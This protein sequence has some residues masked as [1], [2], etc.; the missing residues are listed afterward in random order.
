MGSVP[1]LGVQWNA[2]LAGI[3]GAR[4]TAVDAQTDVTA[5]HDAV[6]AALTAT[7]PATV[8]TLAGGLANLA[9]LPGVATSLSAS[10][11]TVSAE[12]AALTALAPTIQGYAT[13]ASTSAGAAATSAGQALA[14]RDTALAYRDAALAAR[15]LSFAA[16]GSTTSKGAGETLPASTPFTTLAGTPVNAV[17][18]GDS[19]FVAG[20]RQFYKVT[21]Y[22]AGT[23][24]ITW[25]LIGVALL[26][27]A[28]LTA[29]SGALTLTPGAAEH[30]VSNGPML[31]KG[32]AT[33]GRIYAFDTTALDAA[34]PFFNFGVV[35]H[36][37][38]AYPPQ[39]AAQTG[40]SRP[41]L[42]TYWGWNFNANGTRADTTESALGWALESHWMAPHGRLVVEPHLVFIDRLGATHRLV[43]FMCDKDGTRDRGSIRAGLF[44]LYTTSG[45]QAIQIETDSTS[46]YMDFVRQVTLRQATNN[47]A[48]LQQRNAAGN[49]YIT[50]AYLDASDR[51]VLGNSTGGILLAG[52]V[53]LN[54]KAFLGDTVA[55]YDF[56]IGN[57]STGAANLVV[58]GRTEE[59]IRM[60]RNGHDTWSMRMGGSGAS[61]LWWV[62]NNVSG[63]KPMRVYD[64]AD[65][66]F[67]VRNDSVSLGVLAGE[68]PASRLHVNGAITQHQLAAPTAPASGRCI[69]YMDAATGNIVAQVNFGGA[70]KTIVI[71]NYATS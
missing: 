33:T 44:D 17:V 27:G 63:K 68:A 69:T 43:S 71:A 20:T 14:Y 10:A 65:F 48:W 50:L 3:E 28:G 58:N 23:G 31:F 57:T 5:K 32:S 64:S 55:G 38:P 34:A 22:N 24:A 54:A 19:I 67:V 47:I 1:Q 46:G 51:L 35:A 40:T 15:D 56:I 45:A 9:G 60:A 21:A 12:V 39:G 29:P 66:T 37:G 2:L 6:I 7:D 26:Q 53:L 42:V 52:N 16:A 70:T 25:T 62:Q 13:N 18:V 30:V 11:A 8:K 41:N 61:A 59:V 4:D 36:P 49:A